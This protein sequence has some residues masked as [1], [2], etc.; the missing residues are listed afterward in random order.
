MLAAVARRLLAVVVEL[1]LF[2]RWLLTTVGS[3][4]LGLL[5][6]CGLRRGVALTLLHAGHWLSIVL[7]SWLYG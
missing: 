3:C 2:L 7:E 5:M 1:L 6:V 4:T